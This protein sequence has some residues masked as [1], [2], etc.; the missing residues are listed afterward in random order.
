MGYQGVEFAGLHGHE[1][2][3]VADWLAECGLAPA[4]A[5]V[6][7]A[8]LQPDQIEA[9]LAAYRT[10][11]CPW[12]IVPGIPQEMR[13]TEKACLETAD[14]MAMLADGL[15]A[16]GFSC[17]YHCHEADVLP[18]E[19][20]T[21]PWDLIALHTPADFILQYDTSNGVHGGADAVQPILDY[22]GRGQSIHIKEFSGRGGSA[23]V[24]EGEIPWGRV[25]AACEGP[26]KTEWLVVE[27]EVYGERAPMECARLCLDNLA[28]LQSAQRS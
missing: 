3:A 13:A 14:A 17:G 6:G 16:E 27:H 8:A 5:H 4:S 2:A 19:G 7:W 18:L 10:L 25:L 20:G 23:V 28:G 9:T 1:A 24:G 26:A 22:P 15:R 12:L 21:R 11:G